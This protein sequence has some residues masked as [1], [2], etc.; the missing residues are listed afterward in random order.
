MTVLDI[1][2][3]Y[4]K[5][6]NQAPNRFYNSVSSVE[7]KLLNE[8]LTFILSFRI[9]DGKFASRIENQRLLIQI[10]QKLARIWSKS[11]IKDSLFD[12]LQDYDLANKLSK[13][14]YRETLRAP[15]QKDITRIFKDSRPN[16]KRI[17]DKLTNR[18]LNFD[19]VSLNAFDT[20]QDD[21]YNAIVFKENV[22]DL[23]SRIRKTIISTEGNNS[24]ILK[25]V[26]QIS[27]DSLLQYERSLHAQMQQEF[28]LDGF[29]FANSVIKTSRQACVWMSTGTGPLK[30]LAI[31]PGVYKWSDIPEIYNI[32]KG[33][34][35]FDPKTTEQTYVI[36]VNGF[37]CRHVILPIRLIEGDFN[38]N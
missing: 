29:V 22:E 4:T 25:Y 3:D 26:R 24:P 12:F 18:L 21:I 36:I 11:G 17:V 5:L 19:F 34:D 13:Q 38:F 28:D 32:V 30:D 35:G 37:G 9:K 16:K 33:T 1:I 20:I 6:I 7:E 27:N 23:T 14:F 31:R 2:Q 10:E 8:L 15:E